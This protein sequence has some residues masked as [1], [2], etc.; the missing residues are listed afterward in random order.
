MSDEYFCLKKIGYLYDLFLTVL[1]F[2]S[3][4]KIKNSLLNLCVS[5]IIQK[6]ASHYQ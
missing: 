2:D 5:A 6:L 3:I 1:V 4:L